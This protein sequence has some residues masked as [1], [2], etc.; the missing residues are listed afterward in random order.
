MN[1]LRKKQ[2]KI[3][4]CGLNHP[5]D[6]FLFLGFF[7]NSYSLFV[8]FIFYY[9]YSSLI[10]IH[11]STRGHSQCFGPPYTSLN[12]YLFSFVP[13]TIKLWIGTSL[14]CFFS[15]YFSFQQFFFFLTLFIIINWF[16]NINECSIR[17]SRSF[18]SF[19][20][21]ILCWSNLILL[22]YLH[23]CNVKYV[24]LQ[25]SDNQFSKISLIFPE[26]CFLLLAS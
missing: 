5:N 20:T 16:L 19:V 9:I 4:I 2:L 1:G 12:T 7:S 15:I 23:P 21:G 22:E 10:P 24:K 8:N 25:F 3:G 6:P 11:T 26:F 18:S 17:V 14:F 13:S